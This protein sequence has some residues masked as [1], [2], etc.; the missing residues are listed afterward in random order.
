MSDK[1]SK[2]IKK[3]L[4]RNIR[5]FR[6]IRGWSQEDLEEKSGLH[7]TYISGIER[8]VRNPTLTVLETLAK[9]F[10]IKITKLFDEVSR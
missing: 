5:G 8:G 1:A 10:E 2:D 4:A 7:R 9:A 3:I 6:E